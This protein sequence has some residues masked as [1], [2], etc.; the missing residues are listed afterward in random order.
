MN[1]EGHLPAMRRKVALGGSFR[2]LGIRNKRDLR[3]L[4]PTIV[5]PL[6]AT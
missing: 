3:P 4:L 2:L 6:S 1:L 5:L